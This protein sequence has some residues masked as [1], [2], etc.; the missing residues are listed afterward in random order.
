MYKT[1]K[2]G[3]DNSTPH[4]YAYLSNI[5]V[6]KTVAAFRTELGRILRVFRFPSTLVTTVKRGSFRLLCTTLRTEFTLVDAAAA[7]GPANDRSWGT[8]V[9]AELTEVFGTAGTLPCV[10]SGGCS[11]D[12]GLRLPHLIQRSGMESA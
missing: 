5:A 4:F 9:G 8:A 7:A 2:W 11:G 1:K 6:V 10:G 12:L 3:V